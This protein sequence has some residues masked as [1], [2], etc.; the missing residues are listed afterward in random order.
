MN[1][2]LKAYLIYLAI[3]AGVTYLVRALPFI[4]LKKKL[5]NVF[6]RSFLAYVPYAVLSAMTV[7]AI[8][9][10]TENKLSGICALVTAVVAALLGRG[11]VGVAIVACCTVLCVDGIGMLL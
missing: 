9:Y 10:A 1:F 11:L 6:W 7:P 5:Q 4:L 8:F 3:M 2:D